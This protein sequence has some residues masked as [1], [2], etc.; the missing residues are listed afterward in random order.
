MHGIQA[1]DTAG[2][3]ANFADSDLIVDTDDASQKILIQVKS[4]YEARGEWVYLTQSGEQD[5]IK[6]KFRSHFVVF[7]NFDRK[8]AEAHKHKG[9]LDFKHL[10]FYVVP[11]ADANRIYRAAVKRQYA[12]PL[13]RGPKKGG[14]RSLRN[15]DVNA[16]ESEMAPFKNAWDLIRNAVITGASPVAA[17][18]G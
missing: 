15:M 11:C 5:L 12:V 6:D 17:T 9:E 16:S 3:Q 14:L 18:D 2:L 7:V 13:T 8:V 1:Y 10:V 4:G